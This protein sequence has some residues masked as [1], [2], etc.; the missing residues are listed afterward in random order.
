MVMVVICWL[1]LCAGSRSPPSG[2]LPCAPAITLLFT[3]VIVYVSYYWDQWVLLLFCCAATTACMA[4]QGT[5]P[6]GGGR[7]LAVGR[8][9]AAGIQMPGRAELLSLTA[10]E[11]A[12]GSKAHRPNEFTFASVSQS[13][14]ARGRML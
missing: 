6:D 4:A 2:A 10:F 3:S 7:L 1:L 14:Q 5:A 13:L 12:S 9:R 11:A 8:A